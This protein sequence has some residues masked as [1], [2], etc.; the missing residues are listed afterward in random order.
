[1]GIIPQGKT[2]VISHLW[3]H[4][5]S[6]VRAMFNGATPMDLALAYGFTPGQ[7]T[8]ITNSPLFKAELARLETSQEA[9]M[10]SVNQ[11]L[12]VLAEQA[13]E[14][15]SGDFESLADKRDQDSIK[16]KTSM[17]F[18]I[19]DRA[20]YGKKDLSLHLH[21]H[22]YHEKE[23]SLLSDGELFKDVVSLTKGEDESYG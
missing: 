11:D 10:I 22:D 7:I 3:P 14:V 4:H 12:Q 8:R 1:M 16:L 2:P 19:L 20:G 9:L 15:L 17:G 6:M 13:I 23:V 18:G 5:R 21:Q